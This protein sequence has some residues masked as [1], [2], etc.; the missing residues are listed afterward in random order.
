MI[1]S[2]LSVASRHNTSSLPSPLKSPTKVE[3]CWQPPSDP[4]QLSFVKD[5]DGSVYARLLW[6]LNLLM[7]YFHQSFNRNLDTLL[8]K[9]IHYWYKVHL[10]FYHH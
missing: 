6:S 10:F 7:N 8:T 5:P 9:H 3:P 4:F 2:Y 1:K